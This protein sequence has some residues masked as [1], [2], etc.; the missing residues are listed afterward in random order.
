[1]NMPH[2]DFTN[3]T[4]WRVASPSLVGLAECTHRMAAAST[5]CDAAFVRLP[6]APSGGEHVS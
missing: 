2:T 3:L 6:L 4:E 5:S 1:M